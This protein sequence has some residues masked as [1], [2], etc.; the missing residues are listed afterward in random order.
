MQ[1]FYLADP[2]A[3]FFVKEEVS[4]AETRGDNYD[5]TGSLTRLG[6]HAP[7]DLW[8]PVDL[9][10]ST[11][12]DWGTYPDYTSLSVLDLNQREDRRLDVYTALTYHWNQ[13]LATRVFH[14]FINSDNDNGF[15]ER[16]RHLA[17]VEVVF[18]L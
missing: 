8:G 17:G 4:F 9:D 11:G 15:Y 13:D 2:R 16:D 6:L 7:L 3:Y 5:R 14:R 18:S 12:F 10:A 1:Y